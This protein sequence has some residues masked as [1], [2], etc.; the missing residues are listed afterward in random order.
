MLTHTSRGKRTLAGAAVLL[1]A[2][3]GALLFPVQHSHALLLANQLQIIRVGTPPP[4]T[5]GA[6]EF[7]VVAGQGVDVVVQ[8]QDFLFNPSPISLVSDKTVRLTTTGPDSA[9]FSYTA[10]LKRGTSSVTF[11]NV[12][13]TTPFDGVVLTAAVTDGSATS[14]SAD[15]NVTQSGA[16][17]PANTPFWGYNGSAASLT[18]CD[19]TSQRPV[20][21]ELTTHGATTDQLLAFSPCDGTEGCVVGSNIW[22]WLVGTDPATVTRDNPNL[23]TLKLDKT[24]A[25]GKGVAHFQLKLQLVPDGPFEN[26]PPCSGGSVPAGAKFCELGRNSDNAG[27]RIFRMAYI[28]DGRGIIK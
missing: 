16:T 21:V 19:A 27:D 24:I 20:C 7:Q 23:M 12:K 10:T 17:V 28:E 4:D 25:G 3:F 11:K 6:R 9:T 18:G 26:V 1:T 5:P 15:G 2:L 22:T 13:W 14:D 8:S